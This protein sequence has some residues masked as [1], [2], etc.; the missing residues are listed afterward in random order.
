M[1]DKDVVLDRHAF[2]YERMT[3]DLA[4]LADRGILLYFN[5]RADLC[6]VPNRAAVQV[7]ERRQFHVLAQLHVG[8][9]SQ[10][11]VHSATASPRF[12][13]GWLAACSICPTRRPACP[14][15]LGFLSL[16]T[17]STNRDASASSASILS[18][19]G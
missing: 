9:N 1:P 14:S 18:T 15:F 2:A 3:G 4:P 13:T 17:Q 8:S 10:Q 5:E 7:D 11:F 6:A 16:H 19:C 12:S